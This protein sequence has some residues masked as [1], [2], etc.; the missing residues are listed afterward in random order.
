MALGQS[1]LFFADLSYFILAA[2]LIY[3]GKATVETAF[4]AFMASR[5]SGRCIMFTSP[6]I[7]DVVRAASSA[8][9]LFK[10][11]DDEKT[12]R[13]AM[14][15]GDRPVSFFFYI[16]IQIQEI[17]GEITVS[18]VDFSYPIHPN[19]LVS[20][21]LTLKA[22][23]GESIA[24]VGASG[25]GKSTVISLLERF[26]TANRGQIVGVLF[27][28]VIQNLE[29]PASRDPL[30]L[31][32]HRWRGFFSDLNGFRP[33][34]LTFSPCSLLETVKCGR[35]YPIF[36]EN[37]RRGHPFPESTVSS[38]EYSPRLSGTRSVQSLVPCV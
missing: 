2:Y 19:N 35:F 26:Y 37:R 17:L 3:W 8:R 21:Q 1:F 11:I 6:F 10:L 30:A 33:L 15:G 23:K 27:F 13:Q 28:T 5:I 22:M 31:D 29:S 7:P 38:S 25:C 32:S 14:E 18:N 9:E 34:K 20:K 24:L 4:L 36:V 16:Y 12:F